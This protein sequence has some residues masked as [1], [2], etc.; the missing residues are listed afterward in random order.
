MKPKA[1]DAIDY[2]RDIEAYRLGLNDGRQGKQQE[3]CPYDAG[4]SRAC[5]YTGWYEARHERMFD[6]PPRWQ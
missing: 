6:W 5:W 4:D 2:P 1:T 3:A